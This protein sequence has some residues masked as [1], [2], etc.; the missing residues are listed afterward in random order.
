[1]PR[2]GSI[3]SAARI[4]LN[5]IFLIG[6]I[7]RVLGG[8]QAGS[9]ALRIPAT[10][11]IDKSPE[12]PPVYGTSLVNQKPWGVD[13]ANWRRFSPFEYGRG[14]RKWSAQF[15]NLAQSWPRREIDRYLNGAYDSNNRG[16]LLHN[17]RTGQYTIGRH[18]WGIP[19]EPAHGLRILWYSLSP[20]TSEF[21]ARKMQIRSRIPQSDNAQGF[22]RQHA[23]S[24]QELNRLREYWSS[25]ADSVLEDF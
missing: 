5:A 4:D 15:R 3:N 25:F 19:S 10:T 8:R 7:H 17:F 24:L 18:S 6:D 14:P 9:D 21:Q 23:S 1:M 20:W 2:I 22:G 12:T 11:M 13:G 16:R